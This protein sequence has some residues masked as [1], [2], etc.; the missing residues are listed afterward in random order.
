MSLASL[1]VTDLGGHMASAIEGVDLRRPV[2]AVTAAELR[3]VLLDRLVLCF[4]DQTIGDPEYLE[5]MRLFGTP[6]QQLR[7]AAQTRAV[8]EIIVLSSEDRDTLGDGRRIVVGAHWHT[9]DSFKAVPCSLTMLYGVVV[10]PSGGDTQFANMYAAYDALDAATRARIAGLRVIHRYD[11]SR[12]G[13]RVA[14]LSA[15]EQAKVPEVTHPLVRTH[16]ETGRKALYLN[17]NRMEQVVGMERAGS[18]R[19]L[20]EL[21]AHAIQPRF[22]YRHRWRRGDIVV[23]DNRCTMH[24]ANADY[25]ESAQREMHR[26]I[27]EGSVPA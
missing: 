14:K 26:I 17:P 10:P 15:E 2:D 19:L 27:I 5:A 11:S 18:D 25:P 1:T 21:T 16:P 12:K 8:P 20:D 7:V 22:Q 4:R 9:D 24:K 13:T 6:M 23:W 3:R